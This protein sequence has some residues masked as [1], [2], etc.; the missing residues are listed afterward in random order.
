MTMRTCDTPLGWKYFTLPELVTSNKAKNLPPYSKP[1]SQRLQWML[2]NS[3]RVL[4]NM[5]LFVRT[6]LDPLRELYDAPIIVTSCYR[7][8]RCNSMVG[9]VRFSKHLKGLACDVIVSDF[10]R[11]ERI[12]STMQT[13][14]SSLA[15]IR[16]ET[17]IHIQFNLTPYEE[18]NAYRDFFAD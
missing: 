17:F 3:P 2:R 8:P 4:A 10:S 14:L 13:T 6:I 9:G 1:K 5:D 11:L 15:F 12:L 16:Y 7:T 18:E